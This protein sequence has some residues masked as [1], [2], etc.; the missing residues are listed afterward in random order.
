MEMIWNSL[1]SADYLVYDFGWAPV[2]PPAALGGCR[3]PNPP[4]YYNL[5]TAIQ[6]MCDHTPNTTAHTNQ[7]DHNL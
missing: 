1:E 6:H 4:A 2:P 5:G 7:P 3:R